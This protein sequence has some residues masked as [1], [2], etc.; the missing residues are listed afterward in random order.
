MEKY[1]ETAAHLG[2]RGYCVHSL[3]WRGQGLSERMLPQRRKGHVNDYDEYIED[4]TR[5]LDRQVLSETEGPLRLL[6][7]SMG[8]HIA[9]R[10][11]HDQPRR[12]NMAVLVSPMI[13]IVD[14]PFARPLAK[15]LASLAVACGFG[16]LAIPGGRNRDIN[17]ESFDGN[18]LTSDRR[19]FEREVHIL[20]ARPELAVGGLT[21]GWLAATLHSIERLNAPGFAESIDSPSLLF[22]A[23]ADRV[24]S[25]EAQRRFCRRL[26]RGRLVSLAGARHEIL[27]EN[28]ALQGRFWSA[29]DRFMQSGD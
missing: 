9:L 12:F 11:M 4:L 28:D 24:V 13:D 27:Q 19:R 20:R 6:A 2:R 10:F 26:P 29:F 8:A 15:G 17:Q 3:D 25:V 14:G 5:F 16:R 21:F 23:E 18:R 1:A 7:H 22:S